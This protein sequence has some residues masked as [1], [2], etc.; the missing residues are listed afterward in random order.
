MCGAVALGGHWD[1]AVHV[2]WLLTSHSRFSEPLSVRR[3]G[4]NR[5]MV[6]CPK[7]LVR[8]LRKLRVHRLVPYQCRHSGASIDLCSDNRSTAEV[9]GRGRL[10]PKRSVVQNGQAAK[11]T[12]AVNISDQQLLVFFAAAEKQLEGLFF[13]KVLPESLPLP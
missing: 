11:L 6:Q 8:A 4:I 1:M 7:V 13:D 2:L 10:G 3:R 9:K 12:Q 5:P